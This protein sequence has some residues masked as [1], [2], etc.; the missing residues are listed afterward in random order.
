MVL[1]R[2]LDLAQI[3]EICNGVNVEVEAFVHGALCV[4]YSG[5]CTLSERLTGRSADRGECVQAC[6]NLYD[7]VDD[8]G[9]VWLKNKALLSLK[10]LNLSRQLESLLDAGVTSLKI[11]GRLK[12]ISYVRNVVRAYSLRLDEIIARHPGL[13]RRASWGRVERGFTP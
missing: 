11:E 8:S 9:R 6:R 4:C 7:L 5:V 10:D 12:N 13:Y 2:E 3:R 1:E